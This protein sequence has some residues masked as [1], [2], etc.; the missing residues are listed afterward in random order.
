MVHFTFL[1]WNPTIYI[2]LFFFCRNQKCHYGKP[3]IPGSNDLETA[4]RK[5]SL[6]RANE[7][8]EQD[9]RDDEEKRHRERNRYSSQREGCSGASCKIQV[10]LLKFYV[11]MYHIAEL[12][13]LI[14]S[15]YTLYYKLRQWPASLCFQQGNKYIWRNP[16]SWKIMLLFCMLVW[17]NA[18]K[19]IFLRN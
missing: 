14:S 6:R 16:R 8:N 12:W 19:E 2:W 5:L 15:V 13:I 11:F 10:K 1:L 17:I 18:M 9:F 4:L 7:L 3:G